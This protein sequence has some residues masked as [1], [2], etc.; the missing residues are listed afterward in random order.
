MRDFY[1]RSSGAADAISGPS[2]LASSACCPGRKAR[3]SRAAEPG[4][5]RSGSTACVEISD[6]L[7]GAEH[8]TDYLGRPV[9]LGLLLWIPVGD[10]PRVKRTKAG[11]GFPAAMTMGR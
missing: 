6:R 1:S 11:G 7:L 8:V 3:R 9:G 2:S 4:T 10:P 5:S